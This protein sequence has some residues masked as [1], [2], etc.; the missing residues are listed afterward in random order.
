ILAPV[1]NLPALRLLLRAVKA[2]DEF[3]TRHTDP[4]A[5]RGSPE[6]AA[7]LS[8]D[9]LLHSVYQLLCRWRSRAEAAGHFPPSA[10]IRHPIADNLHAPLG[11]LAKIDDGT[12][13]IDSPTRA[14]I[15]L[16]VSAASTTPVAAISDQP[17]TSN[18]ALTSPDKKISSKC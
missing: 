16:G 14:N 17:S 5:R 11:P 10:P 6:P 4:D 8:D 13:A 1:V 15:P 18:D 3:E 12:S 9:Q 7:P 2:L